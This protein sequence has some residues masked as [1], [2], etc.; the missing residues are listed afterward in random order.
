MLYNQY[1]QLTRLI[2]TLVPLRRLG[3]RSF[4]MPCCKKP[5]SRKVNKKSIT[6]YLS[7]LNNL[8]RKT[9]Q[10]KHLNLINGK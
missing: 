6:W 3:F 2:N 1:F 8:I 9:W 10:Y 5:C 4:K 7:S